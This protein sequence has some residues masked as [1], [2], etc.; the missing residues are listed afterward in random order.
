MYSPVVASAIPHLLASNDC[1]ADPACP[2]ESA[3]DHVLI[4]L[5][6][7]QLTHTLLLLRWPLALVLHM[8][9]H[10]LLVLGNDVR[11]L[12]FLVRAQQ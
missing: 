7:N 4:A 11:Y 12:G 2:Q 10:A 6:P 9:L 1:K 3:L 8:L 5:Q